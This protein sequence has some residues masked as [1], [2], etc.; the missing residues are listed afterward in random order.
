MLIP[1][2]RK[3]PLG[4][5]RSPRPFYT[6]KMNTFWS[7]QKWCPISIFHNRKMLYPRCSKNAS[8]PK[9]VPEA[10]LHNKN[11]HFLVFTKNGAQYR[12]SITEK[13]FIPDARKRPLGP[14]RSPRPFYIIKM[15]TFW[16]S[17]KMVPNIDFP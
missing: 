8:G 4:P 1:E 9:A 3:R 13:C 10:I 12:I 6:L 7:S 16:S 2:V 11:D 5:K 17:P 15:I 14:K